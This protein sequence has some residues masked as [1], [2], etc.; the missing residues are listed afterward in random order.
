MTYIKKY[1]QFTI[2]TV[3]TKE[4]TVPQKEINRTCH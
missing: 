4:I 2:Q 1:L 3:E